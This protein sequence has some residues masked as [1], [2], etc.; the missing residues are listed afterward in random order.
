MSQD[1]FPSI[2]SRITNN[3]NLFNQL[4]AKRELFWDWEINYTI[5]DINVIDGII[6]GGKDDGKPLFNKRSYNLPN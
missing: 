2:L 5:G 3:N 4:K 6:K 1:I